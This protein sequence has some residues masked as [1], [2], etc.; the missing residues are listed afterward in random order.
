MAALAERNRWLSLL[1]TGF[2]QEI[3]GVPDAEEYQGC[4]KYRL[5]NE[6]NGERVS[7]QKGQ[8]S[9]RW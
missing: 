3:R 2:L 8:R 6:I 7:P 9:D 4:K 1:T 5:M